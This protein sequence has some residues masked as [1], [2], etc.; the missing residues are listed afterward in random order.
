ME[1]TVFGVDYVGLIQAAIFTEIA[2][3]VACVDVQ[4]KSST[5]HEPDPE[6]L[7]TKNYDAGLI[8]TL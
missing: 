8:I 4:V 7:A 5:L 2:H 3:Q 1:G 6:L